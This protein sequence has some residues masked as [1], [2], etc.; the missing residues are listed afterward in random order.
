MKVW[1]LLILI[2]KV[3]FLWHVSLFD[4][5]S[6]DHLGVQRLKVEGFEILSNAVPLRTQLTR[7]P[8]KTPVARQGSAVL[9]ASFFERLLEGHVELHLGELGHTMVHHG[10][11]PLHLAINFMIFIGNKKTLLERE[12]DRLIVY[13]FVEQ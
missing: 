8:P 13:I 9:R 4:E 7:S 2:L 6:S 3:A 10:G 5:N 1:L 12:A 11:Y